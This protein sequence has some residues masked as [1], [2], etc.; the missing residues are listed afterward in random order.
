MPCRLGAQRWRPPGK[1]KTTGVTLWDGCTE[2][3][4]MVKNGA[5]EEKGESDDASQNNAKARGEKP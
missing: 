5:R 2:E 1:T 4:L 3:A